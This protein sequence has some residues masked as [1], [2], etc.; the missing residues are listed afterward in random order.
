MDLESSTRRV[1]SNL[2]GIGGI[3]FGTWKRSATTMSTY[4][5]QFANVMITHPWSILPTKFFSHCVSKNG[6]VNPFKDV[7]M[8]RGSHPWM[9]RD[10]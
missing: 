10:R 9:S 1:F 2:F 6:C 7:L 3:G 8:V 4:S 5:F